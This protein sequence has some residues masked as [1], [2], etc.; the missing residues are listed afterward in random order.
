MNKKNSVIS[1]FTG[2]GGLD[3][4]FEK[5]GFEIEVAVESDPSCCQTLKVNSPKLKIIQDLIENVSSQ[6]IL[7]ETGLKPLEIA[8]VIGGPPCQ[9]FSLAGKRAG[10][11]DA[12]G[13]L[14]KEFARVVRDTLPVG[15]VLEN[16]KGLVN[17]DNGRAKTALI[18]EFT[19]PVNYKGKTYHYKVKLEILNTT[20]FGVP[21]NRERMFLVGNRIGVDFKF[22]NR[23][24]GN[25]L[26]LLE[27]NLKPFVTVWEAI[28]NLPEPDRPS[29]TALRVAETIIQR[30]IV[31]GY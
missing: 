28:S 21:Q 19:Q 13:H 15:F 26:T 5:A 2:A 4:G 30:R 20:D 23:T 3:I 22:P 14:F 24:H 18:E 12:K 8:L 10:L 29:E 11:N 6:R 9:P 16:V 27:P 17:W 25:E 31:Y 1:L 7:K